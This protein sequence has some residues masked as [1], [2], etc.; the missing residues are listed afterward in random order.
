[1]PRSRAT[2]SQADLEREEVARAAVEV[3]DEHVAEALRRERAAEV[4]EH[5]DRGRGPERERARLRHGIRR[6]VHERELQERAVPV[7]LGQEAQHALGEPLAL[8]R[9]RAEREVRAVHLERR[10]GDEHDG[11]RAVDL[12]ELALR[13]RLPAQDAR[14]GIASTGPPS[15]AR[16]V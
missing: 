1:M 5:R 7:P 12:V 2:R 3:R 13:E 16:G 14:G 10:E 11:A 15:S 9:V 8:E 6:R 4:L